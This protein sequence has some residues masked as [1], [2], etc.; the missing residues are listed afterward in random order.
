MGKGLIEKK[1]MNGVFCGKYVFKKQDC[2]GNG[3]NLWD[4]QGNS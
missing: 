2:Y 3:S 4:W 1:E